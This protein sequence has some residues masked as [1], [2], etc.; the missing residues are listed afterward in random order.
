M[1]GY[2]CSK[3]GAIAAENATGLIWHLKN[4]HALLVGRM[5][6]CPVA[7]GQDGCMRTFRYSYALLRHIQN[8]HDVAGVDNADNDIPIVDDDDDGDYPVLHIDPALHDDNPVAP[9]EQPHEQELGE[10]DVKNSAAIFVAKM[11]APSSMVQSTVDHVVTE[12]SN[13][14][15][16]IVGMLKRKTEVFLQSKKIGEDDIER[17]N[18]LQV[19]YQ[20][21]NPF[22]QLETSHQQQQYFTQS[23]Y[24]IKPGEVLIGHCVSSS[25]QPKHQA[26]RSDNQTHY[27]LIRSLA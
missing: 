26:C 21:Q 14:F 7:C 15:S 16:D 6:T 5:F 18:L 23:G 10:Q 2:T 13:L 3:C 4:R 19:F 24:F 25:L 20:F 11:K 17:E 27:L 8:T 22:A 9:D 1:P 12:A